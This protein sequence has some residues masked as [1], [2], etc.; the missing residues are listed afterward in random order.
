MLASLRFDRDLIR[1]FLREELM[2]G[3]PVYQEIIQ[4]RQARSFTAPT[5][6]PNQ[7]SFTPVTKVPLN[8]TNSLRVPKLNAT[9]IVAIVRVVIPVH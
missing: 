5:H 6:A 7:Y 9:A 3:S 8:F 1:Q 4:Q 2:Q